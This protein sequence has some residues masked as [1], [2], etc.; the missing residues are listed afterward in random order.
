MKNDKLVIDR[1][2]WD[3]GRGVSQTSDKVNLIGPR[4]MCCLGFYG[5]HLGI[6]P[7]ILRDWGQPAECINV[8]IEE[9]N[10]K[11]DEDVFGGILE[12]DGYTFSHSDV[13]A[14]LIKVNDDDTY[15]KESDREDRIV[16]YFAKIN[17]DVTFIN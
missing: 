10:Q 15:Q 8:V 9:L 13:A 3:R 5:V 2:F 14:H 16:E 1:K 17:V 4:G 6:D 7:D 12:Y 11:F